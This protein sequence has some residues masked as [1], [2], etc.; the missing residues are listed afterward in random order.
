M[1]S[2]ILGLD[3]ATFNIINPLIKEGK[4][5][6]FKKIIDNGVYGNIINPGYLAS[7]TAWTTL[8]TGVNPG[9]HGLYDFLSVTEN[10]EFKLNLSTDKKTRS[11]WDI[12]NLKSIIV[13]MPGTYP[14]IYDNENLTVVGCMLT[15]GLSSDFTYPKELKEEILDKIKDYK[16]NLDWELYA[17]NESGFMADL[18]KMTDARLRLFDYLMEN[19]Q[20]DI[21]LGV[22]IGT[23]RLQHLF[24]DKENIFEIYSMLDIYIGKLL[25][26][27]EKEEDII[28]FVISDHG[29]GEIDNLF[30]LNTWLKENGY[31]S[32]KRERIPYWLMR[33]LGIN[34]EFITK[35]LKKL[36]VDTE[37]LRMRLSDRIKNL[38]PP[39]E[40]N[41][42]QDIN[43]KKTKAFF[44]GFGNLYINKELRFK[45]GIVSIGNVANL[46]EDI[47]KKLEQHEAVKKIHDRNELFKGRDLDSGPDL[48]VELNERYAFAKSLGN[49]IV[50]ERKDMKAD[51]LPEGIFLAYGNNIKRRYKR[52]LNVLDFAPTLLYSMAGKKDW[53]MEGKVASDIFEREISEKSLKSIRDKT[54]SEE[55]RIKKTIGS[56]DLGF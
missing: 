39:T 12:L 19:N 9:E 3:G 7:P 26:K 53:N 5:P 56:I 36:G 21:F 11:F 48:L 41:L 49:K 31:L 47:K 27:I 42:F 28:L 52:D 8:T 25:K 14:M 4:L 18:K 46:K 44:F 17:D 13:N 38:A 33:K 32:I 30:Y 1:K 45:G 22:V 34:R 23:D 43:W 20:W 10:H 51:H 55:M 2:I 40:T 50:T 16:I 6:N 29:F 54:K 24:W 15:P 35:V 37:S